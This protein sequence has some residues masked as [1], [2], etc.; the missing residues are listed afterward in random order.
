MIALS[1]VGQTLSTLQPQL[2]NSFFIE[3]PVIIL[4]GIPSLVMFSSSEI[5]YW[6][7]LVFKKNSTLFSL[8]FGMATKFEGLSA[9]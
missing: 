6:E 2:L 3:V 4:S 7:A 9:K 5:F 8:A 1:A